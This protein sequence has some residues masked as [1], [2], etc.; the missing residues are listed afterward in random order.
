MNNVE[1]MLASERKAAFSLA[2]LYVL[3]MLGLFLILPVFALYAEELDGSTPFLAGL[4]IG[5]YGL[6]Q[7]CLQIPF[8]MLSDRF[9]RKRII[10]F[11][12]LIFAFGSVIAA[13]ADTIYWVICGRALQGAGA[14]AA[15]VMA[16]AADLS[17]EE[18]RT[19]VMAIIGV[20]IGFSFALSLV[21]GPILNLWIGVSGIFWLTAVLALVGIGLTKWVVPTPIRSRLHRDTQTVPTSFRRV[22]SDHQLLRL[23]LGIFVLHML[24]MA[25]FVGLP[26]LL[27]DRAGLSPEH[28]WQL[29][30]PA[31]LLGLLLMLPL[32]YMAEKKRRM[33]AMFLGSIGLLL[34]SQLLLSWFADSVM[35]F[36]LVL[37]IF[38]AG[39]NFLEASLPSLIAKLAPPDAKGTALGVYSTSQF[40]G[41]F[42]GGVS[43][44]WLHGEFGIDSIFLFSMILALL[45]LIVA[46]SMKDPRHLSSYLL[47]IGM[48][49]ETEAGSLAQRL[50]QVPGVAEAVVITADGVAYLKVDRRILDKTALQE[51]STASV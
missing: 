21:L 28:H 30:L 8:G 35:T 26:L 33:K 10:V 44:G 27:R 40:L 36:A 23:D 43:A 49:S 1:N 32:I 19:K 16:L 37:V 18:Q 7:A 25:T 48:I 5:I 38:F 17:R 41:A 50:M 34:L 22:L 12:L 15:A 11:G 3:R 2:V 14:I 6:T 29:Y 39:F 45:W 47:N 42:C 31:L 24:L 9:G 4:A 13:L 51:F 20:S 46:F